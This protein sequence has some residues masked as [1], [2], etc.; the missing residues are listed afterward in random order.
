MASMQAEQLLSDLRAGT[1]GDAQV[2]E[3]MEAYLEATRAKYCDNLQTMGQ[4][5]TV[6]LEQQP[7]RVAPCPTCCVPTIL[8]AYLG[9]RSM[10]I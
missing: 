6:N 9:C 7:A 3:G 5:G 1:V 2:V 4:N 8:W 10:I